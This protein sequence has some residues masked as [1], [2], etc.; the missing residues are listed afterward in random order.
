MSNTMNRLFITLLFPISLLAIRF[1]VAQDEKAKPETDDNGAFANPAELGGED[2]YLI[3]LST[4]K[5]IYRGNEVAYFRGIRLHHATQKPADGTHL[6]AFEVI[7]PKGEKAHTGLTQTDDSVYGFMWQIPSEQPGGQY[8]VKLVPSDGNAPAERKFEIRAYRSPRIKSQ[9]TFLRKGHGPGDSVVAYLKA[10]RAEGGIPV[11]AKVS[12]IARVDEKEIYRG[13]TKIDKDGKCEGRFSLPKEITRGEGTLAM[14]VE[15]GGV[16]ETASKTIP[17]LLQTVDL[18]TYPEG[19]NLIADVPNRVYIE[20]FTPALKPADISGVVVDQDGAEIVPFATVHEG[21]GRFTFTPKYGNKYSL[22]I[23]SPSGINRTFPIEHEVNEDGVSLHSE[24]DVYAANERIE[25]GLISSKSE[26]YLVTLSKREKREDSIAVA[27]AKQTEKRVSLDAKESSGVL[28]VTVW[29]E[30]QRP[31]AERLVFR[32]PSAVVNVAIEPDTTEYVPGGTAKITFTSTDNDGNPVSAQIGVTVTDDSVL[33][34]IDKREQAP[35]L[36]AMVLLENEVENLSDAHVYFD[37]NNEQAPRAMDLLLGTQGWRRFAYIHPREL[38]HNFQ[39]AAKRALALRDQRTLMEW[40]RL[41]SFAKQ[42]GLNRQDLFFMD[43]LSAAD[44]G[45][46]PRRSRARRFGEIRADAELLKRFDEASDKQDA[47]GLSSRAKNLAIRQNAPKNELGLE[48]ADLEEQVARE[49][50]LVPH[51]AFEQIQQERDAFRQILPG[52]SMIAVRVYAHKRNASRPQ[53]ERTDFTETLYWCSSITT[54]EN[55]KATVE[56]DLNDSVTSFRIAADAFTKTGS[57]GS[58]TAQIES[59]EPFYVEPKLPLEV[60][61]GDFLQIPLSLI[62]ATSEE[63]S[64]GTLEITSESWKS[65]QTDTTKFKLT[66]KQRARKILGISVGGFQ[67]EA[68]LT[69]S[70]DAGPYGD[71]VTRTLK[72]VPRGFPIED[73]HGGMLGPNA[74]VQH[75]IKIPETVVPDSLTTRVVV[76]PT[77]LASLTEAL[78]GLIRE[79]HG[80]FEQTSSSTFP[81]V[82]AQQYFQSHT[83]VDP[84]LIA[85]SNA[86]LDKGYTRLVGFECKNKGYE[87]FG[88]DP[89]H[90]ALTAYGLLE[91]TEMAR[92][93]EVDAEMI[94]RT[95]DW[96]LSQRDGKGGYARKTRTLHTWIADPECANSYNTWALLE[97]GIETDLSKEIDWVR[98][99]S[100]KTKNSYVMALAANV[101]AKAGDVDMA[102]RLRD[103]LAKQQDKDGSVGGAT[104]SVVGSGGEALKIETTA[105]ALSAWL[106][107]A[108]FTAQSEKAIRFLSQKLQVGTIR[109]NSKYDSGPTSNHPVRQAASQ[110]QGTRQSAVAYRWKGHW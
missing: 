96:L 78:S 37:A 12:V 10:E 29:D 70:A 77:P 51:V 42:R 38:V 24:K 66:A 81:L 54:D 49:R 56:F 99:A 60:T 40:T 31:I 102:D 5:P 41:Y 17:I 89:G 95:K 20:A 92:V 68:D 47:D 27:V 100:L 101:L 84:D 55:G 104:T 7:G 50:K 67:G 110:T 73:N 69:L 94:E 19:G 22:K 65:I 6:A 53:G 36:P 103:R 93:R 63:L 79:P 58:T 11:G 8:T 25:I 82:M 18:S 71:Q 39:D 61:T 72:I 1:V 32:K 46:A 43:S 16:V 9:I 64:E 23:L 59:V 21:R 74:T 106:Q 75:T 2:R 62:N 87:W 83:G 4:D 35:R 109:F 3:H 76:H 97:A 48:L 45:A 91:F 14:V 85:Q 33:E 13:E 15:D 108:K 105:L 86:M 88:S 28:V 107:N 57:I 30:Q 34:M 80:C 26:N 90:D 44:E 52:Q 98:A